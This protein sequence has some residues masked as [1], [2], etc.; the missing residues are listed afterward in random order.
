MWAEGEQGDQD[1]APTCTKYV[2][3]GGTLTLSSILVLR[4]A[5]AHDLSPHPAGDMGYMLDPQTAPCGQTV[6]LGVDVILCDRAEGGRVA[7]TGL[8]TQE[9]GWESASGP[10]NRGLKMLVTQRSGSSQLFSGGEEDTE[11]ATSCS[12]SGEPGTVAP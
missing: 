10:Q 8:H 6:P 12:S 3:P 4:A 7:A 1:G 2:R 9:E 11:V 5:S